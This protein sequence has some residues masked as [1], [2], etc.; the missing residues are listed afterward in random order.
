[1]LGDAVVQPLL[2]TGIYDS[3]Y[4]REQLLG[5]QRIGQSRV[6][7]EETFQQINDDDGTAVIHG[8]L[9]KLR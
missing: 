5:I 3:P 1:M 6:L 9:R 2:A 8:T 7:L 4:R